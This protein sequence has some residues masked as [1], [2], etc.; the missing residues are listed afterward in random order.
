MNLTRLI[1]KLE[2]SREGL[3][4]AARAIPGAHW[5]TPPAEGAWSAAEVVAHITMVE[6]LMT[7]AAAKIAKKPPAVVPFLKRFHIPVAVVAWR[8]VR[9]KSPVPLDTL[10][11]DDREVMLSR[12]AEQRRRTM[13][14]LEADRGTDLR[15]IRVQHPLLGS[16]HYYDWFRTLGLHDIRH[17]KQLREIM[18]SIGP[19][20]ESAQNGVSEYKK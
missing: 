7:G 13:A 14:V 18:Q 8:N 5:R 9:V 6:T 11:L 19:G 4:A 16:L 2:R 10:L 15:R 1:G 17:T 3:E 20:C 12:L